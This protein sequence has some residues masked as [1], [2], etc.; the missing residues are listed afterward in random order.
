[1]VEA[2]IGVFGHSDPDMG[3]ASTDD[4]TLRNKKTVRGGAPNKLESN[5]LTT[6][7]LRATVINREEDKEQILKRGLFGP[8]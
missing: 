1:M 7:N 3:V 6:R 5:T 2:E 8:Q 4:S